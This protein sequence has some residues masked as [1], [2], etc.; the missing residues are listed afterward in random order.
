[1]KTMPYD[2]F[3][4]HYNGYAYK[5]ENA[6]NNKQEIC[7][8]P[9]NA[10]KSIGGT[11]EYDQA[12]TYQDFIKLAE[13]YIHLCATGN[14]GDFAAYIFECCEWQYPETVIADIESD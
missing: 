9:E 5:N 12:Y 2:D 4:D 6:F 1:M 10:I 11:I 13:E 8:I 14:V 7:Y 3:M